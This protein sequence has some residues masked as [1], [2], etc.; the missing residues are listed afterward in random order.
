MLERRVVLGER[1][2]DL[3]LCGTVLTL[4]RVSDGD[5]GGIAAVGEWDLAMHAVRVV[6]IAFPQDVVDVANAEFGPMLRKLDRQRQTGL[7]PECCDVCGVSRNTFP[8][9]AVHDEY[10]NIMETRGNP[11]TAPDEPI[12]WTCHVCGRLVCRRCTL[13]WPGG[14]QYYFHTYCSEACRA[15]APPEFARDDDGDRVA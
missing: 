11:W 7:F 4:R 1:E 14:N 8:E 5:R 6:E 13:T 3:V 15:V 12:R 9:I 10:G 2:F